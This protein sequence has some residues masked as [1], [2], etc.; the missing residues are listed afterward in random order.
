MI[1][2]EADGKYTHGADSVLRGGGAL[3]LSE[4]PPC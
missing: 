3:A 1:L 4:E 2:H